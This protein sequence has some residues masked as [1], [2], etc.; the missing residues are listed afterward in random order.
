M[1]PLQ[2]FSAV[3]QKLV[4][5]KLNARAGRANDHSDTIAPKGIIDHLLVYRTAQNR[6]KRNPQMEGRKSAV[7]RV[8]CETAQRQLEGNDAISC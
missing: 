1:K 8:V 4:S 3:F 2:I 7:S 6:L 5:N